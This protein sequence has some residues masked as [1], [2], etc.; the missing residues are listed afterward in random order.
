[1]E[2]EPHTKHARDAWVDTWHS[3][4][5]SSERDWLQRMIYGD[6]VTEAP[7]APSAEPSTHSNETP[8]PDRSP[9]PPPVPPPSPLNSPQ[10]LW[11]FLDP[12][13]LVAELPPLPPAAA[14]VRD[15][16]SSRILNTTIYAPVGEVK[17]PP[18]PEAI[19]RGRVYAKAVPMVAR[20]PG[21]DVLG[22]WCLPTQPNVCVSFSQFIDSAPVEA[23]LYNCPFNRVQQ[24]WYYI[25]NETKLPTTFV[26]PGASVYL[27]FSTGERL[28]AG[29][30]THR[31]LHMRIVFYDGLREVAHVTISPCAR[32]V[33][34]YIFSLATKPNS[35]VMRILVFYPKPR[36]GAKRTKGLPAGVIQRR[37]SLTFQSQHAGASLMFH[38]T[39]RN[40]AVPV[41]AR[42]A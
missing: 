13:D 38:D 34:R 17:A 14:P 39:L 2:L 30:Q 15:T 31:L 42:E 23:A 35:N 19:F 9:T 40:T 22:S 29:P 27:K 26:V 25:N 21:V 4:R 37:V 36:P 20:L 5:H 33:T 6:D 28:F 11:P 32:D 10:T 18:L 3:K 7:C 16:P 24:E 8:P 1:M 12:L 41:Y